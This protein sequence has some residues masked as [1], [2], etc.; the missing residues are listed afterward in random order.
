MNREQYLVEIRNA[1]KARY[2]FESKH[3]DTVAVRED[4]QNEAAREVAV[5]V[6]ELPGHAQWKRCVAWVDDRE[7]KSPTLAVLDLPTH[8]SQIAAIRVYIIS[9]LTA[10]KKVSR[11]GEEV[12]S[13][14]F[15]TIGEAG[16]LS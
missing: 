1:I 10:Q 9:R 6:F 15:L 12:Y 4:H 16:P 14:G 13:W 7:Q 2:G 3:V 8:L 11:E 5:E